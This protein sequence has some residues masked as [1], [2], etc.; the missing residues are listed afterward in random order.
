MIY[1]QRKHRIRLKLC[2]LRI[3]QYIICYQPLAS[4][5]CSLR[6]AC[7]WLQRPLLKNNGSSPLEA[8]RSNEWNT[9]KNK[10]SKLTPLRLPQTSRMPLRES[11]SRCLSGLSLQCVKAVPQLVPANVSWGFTIYFPLHKDGFT[12]GCTPKSKLNK[13]CIDVFFTWVVLF[14]FFCKR[15]CWV[16]PSFVCST[17]SVQFM[18]LAGSTCL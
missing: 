7:T 11:C 1:S 9:K 2:F 18:T 10:I 3:C 5:L 13:W 8:V 17:C 16:D 4:A 14:F 12:L 6:E 15:A